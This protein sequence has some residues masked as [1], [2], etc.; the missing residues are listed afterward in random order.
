[1]VSTPGDGGFLGIGNVVELCVDVY[2]VVAGSLHLGEMNCSSHIALLFAFC[3]TSCYCLT[4]CYVIR[5]FNNFLFLFVCKDTTFC[6]LI[7]IFSC[8]INLKIYSFLQFAIY[9]QCFNYNLSPSKAPIMIVC[10]Y[11]RV[12][13]FHL[14][15]FSWLPAVIMQNVTSLIQKVALHSRIH[16]RNFRF[17]QVFPHTPWRGRSS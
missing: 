8:K 1:M 12:S 15:A 7:R 4:I 10:S 3:S 16:D 14:R 13:W 6:F 5:R 9:G 11:F 17:F 2:V